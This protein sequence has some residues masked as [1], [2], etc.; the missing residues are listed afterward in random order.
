M[1]DS[2]LM[3]SRN[4]CDK[5]HPEGWNPN[6]VCTDPYCKFDVKRESPCP[7]LHGDNWAKPYLEAGEPIPDSLQFGLCRVCVECLSA[8]PKPLDLVADRGGHERK[9]HTTHVSRPREGT[10]TTPLNRDLWGMIGEFLCTESVCRITAVCKELFHQFYAIKQKQMIL[11]PPASLTLRIH[12]IM[13]EVHNYG[14][15]FPLDKVET[16]TLKGMSSKRVNDKLREELGPMWY[17]AVATYPVSDW[18]IQTLVYATRNSTPAMDV[19][20]L[21]WGDNNSSCCGRQGHA[22]V[23]RSKVNLRATIEAFVDEEL[24][25]VRSIK[26]RIEGS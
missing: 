16:L 22:R 1:C 8:R 13:R 3:C 20:H 14:R 10:D 6:M 18:D 23:C 15:P 21:G 4:R 12:A 25:L 17:H 24:A 7:K 11:A 19:N 2:G 5:I 26:Q 9:L